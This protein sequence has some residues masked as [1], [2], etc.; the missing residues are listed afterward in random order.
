MASNTPNIL[1]VTTDQHHPNRVGVFDPRMITPNLDRMAR[2]GA[3]L[4]RSYVTCPLCTPTRATWITG[5]YPSRHG[6]WTIGTVLRKDCHS[7]PALLSQAGYRTAMFGKSHLEPVEIDAP[8]L[9]EGLPRRFDTDHFRRWHGPWYGFQHV[10]INL[11]HCD[12]EQ[13]ASMHYRVWLEDRGIDPARYF[14]K[15]DPAGYDQPRAWTLDQDHHP[16]AWATDR[17]I[18]YLRDHMGRHPDRPFYV[19]V[20]FPEPHPPFHVPEPWYSLAAEME[21]GP[22]RRRWKEWQDKPMLYRALLD[23]RVEDLGW[24]DTF[25]VPALSS[26]SA[27][28]PFTPIGE[29]DATHYREREA[30]WMRVYCGMIAMAD[31]HLGRLLET[32]DELALAD[33]TL[34]LFTADHGGMMGDHFLYG[35]GAC[36]YDGCVRVPTF[37]RWGGTVPA[38][39][40]SDA[41]VSNVDIGPTFLAAAGLGASPQMQGVSQL[42]VFTGRQETARQ[43]VLVDHRAERGLYVNTWITDRYRLSV[44]HT[45]TP[46]AEMELYDLREDPDEMVNLTGDRRH[47]DDVVRMMAGMLAERSRCGGPWQER[48]AFA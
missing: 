48:I 44:H 1:F 41:L 47:G 15:M 7:L 34:V 42:G 9:T 30:Q 38:G 21:I 11:G 3:T 10:E 32:L 4:T 36:H 8:D 43:G 5:Q 46:S 13:S 40:R 19:N 16:C 14:G 17:A 24:H 22:P 26:I 37:A 20:N 2:E 33:N 35:K 45:N 29:R 6:A 23:S 12:E 25:G 27:H 39:L 28:S 31:H 18:A